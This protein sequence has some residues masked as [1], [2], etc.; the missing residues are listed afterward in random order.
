MTIR[1][2]APSEVGI[3]H[4]LAHR[5]WPD[6]FSEILSPEQ[7]EYMLEWMYNEQKLRDQILAGHQ[8]AVIEEDGLPLGFIGMESNYQ[9]SNALRIHKL[10][11]LPD[12]QGKGLGKQLLTFADQEAKRLQQ[13]RLH[14]NVNRFNKAVNF[15]TYAGF[16]IIQEENIDI[17]KGYLM[18]D[19]VME[20]PV[21]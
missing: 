12:Q 6:T 18:E 8:F 11:V 10:Y 21:S 1:T 4:D 19:Y 15:Y 13:D 17:G 14:L 5:I 7:I 16:T 9:G 2:I 3:V 20:R